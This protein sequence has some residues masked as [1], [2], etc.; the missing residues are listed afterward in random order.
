[1]YND[2]QFL[3]RKGNCH[4]TRT[5]TSP[6][7][8]ERRPTGAT[9]SRRPLHEPA[10]RLG[11]VIPHDPGPRRGS[12]QP[13]RGRTRRSL[14]LGRRPVAPALPGA[15]RSGSARRTSSRPAPHLR[16]R[17]GRSGDQP[18]PAGEAR[19]RR[20]Q[21]RVLEGRHRR[22]LPA[23]GQRGFSLLGLQPHLAQTFK[24]STDPFFLENVRD[25]GGLDLN[26]PDHA[27][28][29]GVDETTQIQA[30]NRPQPT[31]LRGLRIGPRVPSRLHAPR[32]DLLVRCLGHRHRSGPRPMQEAVPP[33]R[34]SSLSSG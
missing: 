29:L 10:P 19:K 31:W 3:N 30:L 25:L 16:R 5:P 27:M 24:L 26:P 9:S 20:E 1:M 22:R 2:R 34:T 33:P 17:E 12:Q 14:V 11:P 4:A 13:G 18:R 23:P 8:S 7:D 28:G 6:F 32:P 15:R 21:E